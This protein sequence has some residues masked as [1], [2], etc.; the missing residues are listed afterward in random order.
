LLPAELAFVKHRSFGGWDAVAYAGGSYTRYR[1]YVNGRVY[2]AA[3]ASPVSPGDRRIRQAAH[4]DLHERLQGQGIS[5]W[6]YWGPEI[7][8]ATRR[9]DAFAGNNADGNALADHL[10][11]AL[12]A[13]KRHWMVHTFIP[14]Q[15]RLKPLIEAYRQIA[16]GE[17]PDVEVT[18][19]YLLQGAETVQT[20]LVE[21]LYDLACLARQAP[22]VAAEVAGHTAGAYERMQHLPEAAGFVA[23][24]ERLLATYGGRICQWKTAGS[25]FELPLPWREAPEYVLGLVA[26]YLPAAGAHEMPGPRQARQLAASQVQARVEA[27]CTASDP[28]A[29]RVFRQGLAFAR[30]NATWTD[31]HNHY[32]D[33]LAEGQYAQALV[34]AGRWLTQRGDLGCMEEVF[35]LQPDEVLAA[36]RSPEQEDFSAAIASRQEQFEAWNR[37]YAPAILGLPDPSLPPR[38]VISKPATATTGPEATAGRAA[39]ERLLIGQSASRGQGSGPARLVP[40]GPGLPEVAPGEVLVA[41]NAGPEWTPL[42]PALAGIVLD[43]GSIGDHS[44]ITAR[45][46]GVPAVFATGNASRRIPAGAWVRVDGESGR[47][48]W[49]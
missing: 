26:S 45:E 15:G 38:P 19:I 18:L 36:L 27:L 42:L 11:D 23:Q 39:Q 44:A 9:L 33:Q 13:A 30:R 10:E 32:I 5:L 34:Y 25:P 1:K 29:A 4:Q 47:V 40:A 28:A 7:E 2:M 37:L 35:W 41:V 48:Q 12:A 43:G 6:E 20:R 14:R 49:E 31:E 24:F 22:A 8:R 17:Q 21:A 46:F 3:D 16:G